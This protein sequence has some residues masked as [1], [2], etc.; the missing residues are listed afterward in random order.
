MLAAERAQQ[1]AE[2][3]AKAAI[4][5]EKQLQLRQQV[6]APPPL[7]PS[8]PAPRARSHLPL[9]V[10]GLVFSTHEHW[11]SRTKARLVRVPPEPQGAP[12]PLCGICAHG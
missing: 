3:A 7:L 5:L 9:G 11:G 1:R 10:L 12:L 2:A 6:P 4:K 8:R